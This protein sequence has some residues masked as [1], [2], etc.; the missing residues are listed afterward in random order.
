MAQKPGFFFFLQYLEIRRLH[1]WHKSINECPDILT[2]QGS[3]RIP[4][5]INQFLP[6]RQLL[7]RIGRMQTGKHRIHLEKRSWSTDLYYKCLFLF[8]FSFFQ[9]TVLTSRPMFHPIFRAPWRKYLK[10]VKEVVRCPCESM[11]KQDWT[12][13]KC[14]SNLPYKRHLKWP[15]PGSTPTPLS[16]GAG[17]TQTPKG[18]SPTGVGE[19]PP[20]GSTPNVFA[21]P[22]SLTPRDGAYPLWR[23]FGSGWSW[24]LCL[25]PLLFLLLF[26]LLLW[27]FLGG[28][29]QPES[30][31]GK[32]GEGMEK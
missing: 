21:A 10:R 13:K 7:L 4:Q 3:L 28:P 8:W 16:P 29:D 14:A 9:G 17:G 31:R 23:R 11:F 2:I 6:D 26:F 12:N 20:A 5:I 19:W 22:V 24:Q 30:H 27:S 25:L 32:G 1:P 18:F 15:P